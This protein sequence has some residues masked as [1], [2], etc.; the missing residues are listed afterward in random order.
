M[1]S[2]TAEETV[3]FAFPRSVQKAVGN[4]DSNDHADAFHCACMY[5]RKACAKGKPFHRSKISIV[6]AP[7]AFPTSGTCTDTSQRLWEPD[8]SNVTPCQQ[9]ACNA[10]GQRILRSEHEKRVQLLSVCRP[11]CIPLLRLLYLGFLEISCVRDLH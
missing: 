7:A 1:K 5:H 3:R 8:R 9:H 11:L 4:F 6:H 10:V 2:N